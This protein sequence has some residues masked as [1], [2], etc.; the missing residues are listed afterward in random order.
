MKV[1]TNK[2]GEELA[3]LTVVLP[4]A[5][6]AALIIFVSIINETA[7]LAWIGC[8]LLVS[9]TILFESEETKKKIYDE[10][11]NGESLN[12]FTSTMFVF[13]AAPGIVVLYFKFLIIP[14]IK[15]RILNKKGKEELKEFDCIDSQDK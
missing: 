7:A 5:T 2:K 13:L 3:F 10:F 1:I 14:S 8:Q 11:E 4:T 15:K 12:W 9:L 6:L